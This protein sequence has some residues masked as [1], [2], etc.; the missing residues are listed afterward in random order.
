MATVILSLASNR[1]QKKHLAMARKRLGEMLLDIVY[2]TEVWTHPIGCARRDYYLNQLVKGQC[3]YPLEE[4]SQQLKMIEN[5]LGRTPQ[6]REMGIVPIDLDI[7]EYD[8]LR[9]HEK[10]GQRPYV[11]KLIGEL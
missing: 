10:D 1:Y 11:T 9:F 7:L 6:K 4:L 5:E 8:H 3:D 2:T